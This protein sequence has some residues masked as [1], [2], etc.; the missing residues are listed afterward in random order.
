[1]AQANQLPGM[2]GQLVV[3][4]SGVLLE[5]F[6]GFKTPAVGP[7]RNQDGTSML[8][9]TQLPGNATSTWSDLRFGWVMATPGANAG[10]WTLSQRNPNGNEFARC[11]LAK[12]QLSCG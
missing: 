3:G 4:N 6:T 1:M 2:P 9:G 11:Q 12:R 7:L 5:T 8:P 10:E